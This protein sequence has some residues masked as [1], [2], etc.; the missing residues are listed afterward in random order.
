[1]STPPKTRTTVPISTTLAMSTST[2]KRCK[3]WGCKMCSD[4]GETC[5]QCD[6]SSRFPVNGKC[7]TKVYCKRNRVDGLGADEPEVSC[8]CGIKDCFRCLIEGGQ[9]G[10]IQ[11]LRCKN[12]KYLSNG[13]CV[14][15][16]NCAADT[17]PS[18]AGSY[19]RSCAAPYSCR[20][21]RSSTDNKPC[22]CEAPSRCFSCAWG[23]AGHACTKCKAGTYLHNGECVESCPSELTHN[24][25]GS[26]GRTCENAYICTAYKNEVTGARC[27][28]PNHKDCH[29]CTYSAGNAPRTATCI[30]CKRGM[31][32]YDDACLK[33]CPTGT[34]PT[35]TGTYGR[36][37]V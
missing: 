12:G 27:K 25:L 14:E 13:V 33:S 37:C 16:T 19:G 29:S 11:C 9:N 4:D 23:E 8:S 20:K 18:G 7:R 24:G 1:M 15:G 35:G 34:T 3:V 6:E 5:L 2:T 17:V 36:T 10:N 30:K 31:F 22:K 32:L 28:C 21:G 26:Y